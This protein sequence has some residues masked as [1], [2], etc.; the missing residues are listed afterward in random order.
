MNTTTNQKVTIS[1]P[2]EVLSYADR[3]RKLHG[4]ATRSEVLTLALKLLRERELAEGY[5]A[6]AQ[7][8]DELADPWLDSGLQESLKENEKG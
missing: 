6:M 8:R 1:L 7:D 2:P 3:Y 4:L 5:R